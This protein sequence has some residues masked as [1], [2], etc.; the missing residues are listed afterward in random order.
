[1]HNLFFLEK[2]I[3]NIRK[4]IDEGSFKEF[5]QAFKSDYKQAEDHQSEE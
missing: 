1:M 4:S 2:L 5:Y 3:L